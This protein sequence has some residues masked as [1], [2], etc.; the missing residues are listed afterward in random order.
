MLA[1]F[2]GSK[3]QRRLPLRPY[4]SQGCDSIE[5]AWKDSDLVL[6]ELATG[7]G[8]SLLAGE[9]IARRVERGERCLMLAHT[10]KL[11]EQFAQV[12]EKDYGIWSTI[13]MGQSRSEDSP[14]VCA[15][16]QTL[17]NRLRKEKFSTDEFS[18]VIWDESHHVLSATHQEIAKA[19]PHA[20]HLGITATPMASGQRDLMKFFQTKA[21]SVK[22]DWLIQNGFLARLE[23]LNIPISIRIKSE[24]KT[25]DITEEE[26]GAAIEPYLESCAEWL[27]TSPEAKGK[28]SLVFQP[29]IQTS[30]KFVAMLKER[31]VKAEHMDGTMDSEKRARILK[32]YMMGDIHV[33]SN[34]MLLTEGVDLPPVNLLMN[35]RCTRSWVLWCQMIGRATRLFDPAKN[36]L[37]GTKW[38]KKDSALIVDPLWICDD[39]NPMKMPNLIA[40]DEEEAKAIEKEMKKQAKSGGK[41]DLIEAMNSVSA[42]REETLRRRLEAMA[43]RK[44]RLVDSVE[45]FVNAIH[46]PD[47]AEWEPMSQKDLAPLTDG[48]RSCLEK[49]GIDLESIKGFGHASMLIDNLKRERWDKDLATLKQVKYAL[50]LGA[51]EGWAWKATFKEVSEYLNSNAPKKSYGPY[52]R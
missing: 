12:T 2:N 10:R 4:Q 19:F 20:K 44:S 47:L 52:R 3:I 45:F 38:G 24:A 28:C 48:Q 7:A 11:V 42:E 17:K 41:S 18:L 39:L 51:D 35:L 25:G 40:K 46:R 43:K 36:G 32:S 13:E 22:L 37:P 29:L 8:K 23:H 1:H 30:M 26:C 21:C 49:N 14:L 15:S 31:G 6:A 27:A 5:D 33:I 34:S 9:L 16:V 50:S